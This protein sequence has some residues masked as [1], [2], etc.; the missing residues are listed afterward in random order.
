MFRKSGAWLLFIIASVVLAPRCSEKALTFE[1]PTGYTGWVTVQFGATECNEVKSSNRITIRVDVEGRGCSTMA[2]YPRNAWFSRFYYVRDGRRTKEL[3]PTGWGKGGMIWAE[4]TEIDGR[5]YR[6]FVGS[7]EQ[8]NNVPKP[9][10]EVN[11]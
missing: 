10:A 4:S 1:I 3:S 5:Q 8:F 6:F 2:S 7:E 11:R 9:R